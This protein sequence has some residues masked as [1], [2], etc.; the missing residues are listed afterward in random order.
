MSQEPFCDHR[1]IVRLLGISWDNIESSLFAPLMIVELAWTEA[2]TLQ[3]YY[4][5]ANIN[6]S[7]ATSRGIIADIADGLSALHFSDVLHSDLKPSNIFL[8]EEAGNL[9]AKVGDFGFSDVDQLLA[10]VNR[11]VRGVT[12]EWCAPELLQ[13]CPEDIRH[14]AK[15]APIAADIY[16]FGL[17]AA[18]IALD[19]TSPQKLVESTR[20]ELDQLKFNNLLAGQIEERLGTHWTDTGRD[21]ADLRLYLS[22][23]KDT[24][25]SN[26]TKRIASL[27][28][29]RERLTG[30]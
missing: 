9:V 14:S 3:H 20:E 2:P 23:L 22:L 1:N 5:N 13:G 8:F 26:P 30:K 27:S 7:S 6:K 15:T 11:T 17:V 28:V 16:S 12:R 21:V 10:D 4:S 25:T 29:V 24:I 18:F 19:G